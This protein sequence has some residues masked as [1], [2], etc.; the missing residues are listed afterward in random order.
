MSDLVGHTDLR[1]A[2]GSHTGSFALL[3]PEGVGR[4]AVVTEWLAGRPSETLTDLDRASS[5]PDLIYLL[6][7][8]QVRNWTPLLRP[9]EEGH[10]T[11]AIVSK[12]LPQP[13]QTRLPIFRAGL[14]SDAE[15]AQVL[16]SDFPRLQPR[17]ILAKIAQGTLANIEFQAEVAQTFETF[18]K[19][20]ETRH[21]PDFR[22]HRPLACYSMMTWAARAR[23][24][25]PS[26]PFSA[27]AKSFFTERTA[28]QFLAYPAP[29]FDHEA[30]NLLHMV[31]SH[32][33]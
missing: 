26:L 18:P 14:L 15:V 1:S 32:H 24:H 11:V 17:P 9:L 3:G 5:R 4:R 30:R 8:D 20:L 7:G 33:G 2:L 31:F 25:L 10:F 12:S 28:I 21:L 22:K 6:D 23:L 13:V 19:A 29:T 27:E 16:A